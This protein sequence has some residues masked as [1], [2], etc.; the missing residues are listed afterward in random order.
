MTDR[1]TEPPLDP[2]T[3][4]A[5]DWFLRLQDPALTQDERDAFTAWRAEPAQAAAFD[6][7]AALW[8]A[9]EL[10]LTLQRQEVRKPATR[11]RRVWL[12]AAAAMAASVL[13]MAGAAQ[14][15]GLLPP[16]GADYV[17]AKGERRELRLADG[18]TLWLNSG[19]AVAVAMETGQ[20]HVRLLRGEAYFD[21]APDPAR[22]FRVEARHATVQV[23]GTAFSVETGGA[24]DRV[25][26][27]RGQ[28]AVS[29]DG[30][31]GWVQL[32]A[33]QSVEVTALGTGPAE[34]VATEALLAWRQGRIRFD[35]RPL[36]EVLA[37][38]GRYY[39]GQILIGDPRLAERAISGDYRLDDPAAIVASLAQAVGAEVT[40][41]PGGTLLMRP[42]AKKTS[43]DS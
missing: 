10:T 16:L 28:V 4:E 20:R 24:L 2:T 3:A 30:Q 19:S 36:G 33:D 9:P 43:T 5:L 26:V 14:I 23:V 15:G 38:L 7:I 42:A 1:E 27:E 39:G 32:R 13:I 8:G 22:P 25:T 34:A 21:V 31:T 6:R 37:N 35:Q 17:T 18:S 11:P 40:P 29:T 41:L 12:R